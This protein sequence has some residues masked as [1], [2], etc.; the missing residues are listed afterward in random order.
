[1]RRKFIFVIALLFTALACHKENTTQPEETKVNSNDIEDL[2]QEID[3]LRAIVES[4]KP[5]SGNVGED[6]VKW[7]SSEEFESLRRENEELKA[8]VQKLTADFFEV[9]GLRFDKNGV[10]VSTQVLNKEVTEKISEDITHTITRTC[11]AEGRIIEIISE[12]SGYNSLSS[13]PYY[14]KQELF[15]YN[16]KMCK[17]TERTNMNGQYV[18]EV[19]E[20]TYW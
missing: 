16:G 8:Q 12:Y 19:T 15:E 10:L 6:D 14:W 13:L 20:S 4:L 1:M 18:E 2:R 11:D 7:V 3:D 17:K 9:D 5:G